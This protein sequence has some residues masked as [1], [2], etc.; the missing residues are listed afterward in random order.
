MTMP[1]SGKEIIKRLIA[2]GW[3]IDRI[4]GSHYVMAKGDRTEVIPVH[5]NQ[6]MK[7]GLLAAILKR[8]GLK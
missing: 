4:H 5:G 3:H 7:P 6:D 8:T 1:P 2:D